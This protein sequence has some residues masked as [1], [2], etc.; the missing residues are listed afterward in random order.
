MP[1][2]YT[3]RYKQRKLITKYDSKGKAISSYEEF[4]PITLSMLPLETALTYKQTLDAKCEVE[5]E[6]EDGHL[7]RERRKSFQT[8]T[9]SS[10]DHSHKADRP[11]ARTKKPAAPAAAPAAALGDMTAALNKVLEKGGAA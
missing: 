8:S 2:L 6:A 11:A 5:I 9:R 10:F 3:V 4:V 1:Q 7:D